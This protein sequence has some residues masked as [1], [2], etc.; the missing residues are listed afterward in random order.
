[1]VGKKNFAHT[2]NKD[3]W[4]IFLVTRLNIACVQGLPAISTSFELN[5]TV[6][7]SVVDSNLTL[8]MSI[9]STYTPSSGQDSEVGCIPPFGKFV[10]W[11]LP[12]ERLW[13]RKRVISLK[14]KKV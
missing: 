1:M 13:R 14:E 11:L 4:T 3:T 5:Y 6:L 10:V 7:R 2:C 9:Q 8:K 12:M